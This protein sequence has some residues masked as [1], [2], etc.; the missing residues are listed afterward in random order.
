MRTNSAD[1]GPKGCALRSESEGRRRGEWFCG[2]D[3]DVVATVQRFQEAAT[4]TVAALRSA[5]IVFLTSFSG[6]PLPDNFDV[7][8]VGKCAAQTV[9]DLVLEGLDQYELH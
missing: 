7:G 4:I 5:E 3:D 1:A 2:V 9:K 8:L 6:S